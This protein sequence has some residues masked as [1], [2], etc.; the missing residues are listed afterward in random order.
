MLPRTLFSR[1]KTQQPAIL[2]TG[3]THGADVS[4]VAASQSFTLFVSLTAF[5]H[6]LTRRYCNEIRQALSSPQSP[7]IRPP[8]DTCVSYDLDTTTRH[9]RHLSDTKQLLPDTKSVECPYLPVDNFPPKN[10]ALNRDE[11]RQPISPP[12]LPD[13]HHPRYTCVSYA[14]ATTMLQMLHFS[15]TNL[16]A[17]DTKSVARPYLTP[18]HLPSNVP[19]PFHDEIRQPWLAPATSSIRLNRQLWPRYD[20]ATNA[21]P[22]RYEKTRFSYEER[23]TP[24]SGAQHRSLRTLA[25][26][27]DEIRQPHTPPRNL[28]PADSIWP[29]PTRPTLSAQVDT[30]HPLGYP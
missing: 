24:L 3:S 11:I 12:Q 29:I 5:F 25:P 17:P 13:L 26:L 10:Y 14:P 20:H 21:T 19:A 16:C 28:P 1:A 9:I 22:S 7:A 15:D 23:L 8:F 4:R 2:Y 6:A 18:R 30:S 27:N